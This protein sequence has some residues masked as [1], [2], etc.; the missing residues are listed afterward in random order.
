MIGKIVFFMGR[1]ASGKSTI[2][3][4]LCKSLRKQS[5]NCV[6]V[7]ADDLAKHKIM[8]LV[9]NFSL[10]ARLARAPHLV[11]IVKWLQSQFDYVIIAATGQPKGVRDIFKKEF[12]NYI[13]IYLSATLD[14]CKKRDFKGIYK[15]KSV[16]G[17]D[18]P[19]A[20]PLDCDHIIEINDLSPIDILDII[21]ELIQFK[22]N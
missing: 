14:L 6:M 13:S 19:F 11:K 5:Y 2:S 10:E 8:P 18:L 9:G 17:L 4:L 16:L 12:E 15:M 7:D 1:S 3:N 20:E 21:N 22:N